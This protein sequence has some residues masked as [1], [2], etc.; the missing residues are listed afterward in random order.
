MLAPSNPGSMIRA[1]SHASNAGARVAIMGYDFR[2]AASRV[3][4][5]PPRNDRAASRRVRRVSFANP[6]FARNDHA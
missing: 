6:S 1:Q 3:V 4:Q 2:R 5:L